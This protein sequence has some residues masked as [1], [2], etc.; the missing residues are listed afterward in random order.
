M[1]CQ[2]KCINEDDCHW[3]TWFDT[4][5]YLLSECGTTAHCE[6]CVSGPTTPD[7]STCPWPPGPTHPTPSSTPSTTPTTTT[8]TT[9][10]STTES[11]TPSTTST[12]TET[13]T[14]STTKSTTTSTTTQSQGSCDDIHINEECDW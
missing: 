11:T 9:T 3:F 8:S 6:G 12:T 4:N 7:V 13:T 5:C 14:K 1:G 10:E 2:T